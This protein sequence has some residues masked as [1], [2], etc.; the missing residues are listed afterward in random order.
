MHPICRI[1]C[2]LPGWFD[3]A[4]T[5]LKGHPR[6][7][8]DWQTKQVRWDQLRS[9]TQKMKNQE[10]FS[11][12]N[13]SRS[14]TN[15]PH[16]DET[17]G[18]ASHGD[19][20]HAHGGIFGA[21]TELVFVALAGVFLLAGWLLGRSG[22][23]NGWMPIALL[24]ISYFFGGYFTLK[25]A[26]GKLLARRFEIDTLMLVAAVG[27]AALGEW[28]EG[29][30]LLFLFSLGHSLEHYAMG[31]ARR[32]I[33]ALAEL[34][35]ETANVRRDDAVVEVAVAEL[36][37]GD[38]I[39]VRPNERLPA[40]GIVTVG[41]TSVNQAPVTGESVPVE[42]Q[43][44]PDPAAAIATFDRAKAE[45]R[46]FAGTING[47]GAIDVMVARKADQ[48][49][50]ARVVNMVAEAEAQ[51]SPTQQWTDRFERIFVPAVL[52]LVGLLMLACFVID[53]PFSVSFYRAMAV[54]VAASPCALAIS[55][56][57]AVLSG[58][59][60]AARGGVLVKGGG[61]L[62]NLGSLTSIAFDKTGTLTEGKP[63]LTDVV[64]ADGVTEQELLSVALAIEQS[65]DHPLA[66]AVV[67]GA[68][69][70]LGPTVE[71][72]AATEVTSITGKGIQAV[73]GGERVVIGKPSLFSEQPGSTVPAGVTESNAGLVATGR[74][75]MMIQKG[76]RFLGVIGVM[77]TPR[78]AA[79]KV[80]DELRGLG[81]ER[82][83]M[84]SGD[85]QQVADAVAK[86]VG[87]TEAQGNL[88]PEQKVEAIKALRYKHGKVA[89]VG[90]GVNDAPAMA[91]ATVG[92]AMGAAGSDVALETAD[93]A[94]MSDDLGHLPFAVGLS[95]RTSR[96]IK[97]NL[98]VSLGV[99]AV[100]IPAT[101]FGLNIG[102]AVLFH[103]G[104]TLLVVVNAL[105]LLAYQGTG[106]APDSTAA[107]V[108][109]QAE[110]AAS[111]I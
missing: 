59:A 34:A 60:R 52:A 107:T 17:A 82:L 75:T 64:P 84:I 66:S 28:A 55:V 91:N 109:A 40:D 74:T 38:V 13:T 11:A 25:E 21:N 68:K 77:D 42:K 50:M 45:H 2:G 26:V 43:P 85:N 108:S 100:L 33:E 10:A 37:V 41:T 14:P 27:A 4:L 12:E 104:S 95:R 18:D 35:P 48:S 47:T 62:E 83:I 5:L 103:E 101:L 102:T 29:A 94:L 22:Q 105:R 23:G 90:D 96:I 58:V 8:A 98:W 88:M 54:L 16:A 72:L 87:L 20:E 32:A 86:A 110:G 7:I 73:V 97:Q 31:R 79:R 70:R 81:I 63:R 9:G 51:R 19:A 93:V 46:V 53:E 49:T 15:V 44:A 61:P 56:P 71:V 89:M 76:T 111:T 6:L 57:S 1:S 67:A 80:M 65:S 30:L 99:V 3:D 39:V 24:V 92:I 78:P 106:A 36:Q 69:E